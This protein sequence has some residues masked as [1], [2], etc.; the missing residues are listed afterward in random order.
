M[1]RLFVIITVAV[2][3]LVGI[4]GCR[5]EEPSATDILTGNAGWVISKAFSNPPYYMSE[6]GSFASDLINDEYFKDFEIAYVL[7]FNATGGEIVKP[8][9]VVA[10][11]A[12]EGY[13]TETTLGNWVFDNPEKPSTITMYIPFL[14]QDE[15]VVCQILDL[16]KDELR[17][18]FTVEDDEDGAKKECSFTVTYVPFN[19][20][21]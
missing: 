16:T 12:E 17:I 4:S 3:S 19:R 9:S 15:P 1:N 11:S 2:L 8:G 6:S 18:R 7:V 21:K 14:Y 5:Q 13:V 10:P 20:I